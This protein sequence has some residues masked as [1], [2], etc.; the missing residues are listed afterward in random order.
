MD[1]QWQLISWL[2]AISCVIAFFFNVKK[3]KV[4]FIIW[5]LA[6]LA[7]VFVNIW[8]TR[9]YA[10]ASLNFLYLFFNAYGWYQWRKDESR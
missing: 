6:A 7:F 4:C 9:D 8:G 10:Q 2:T 3:D 5:E 1:S